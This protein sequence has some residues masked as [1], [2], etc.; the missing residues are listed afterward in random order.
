[1]VYNTNLISSCPKKHYI[2]LVCE[3][4]TIFNQ[5]HTK[6]VRYYTDKKKSMLSTLFGVNLFDLIEC[7]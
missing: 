6:P 5:S 2:Y 4:L 7:L 1:M 3:E